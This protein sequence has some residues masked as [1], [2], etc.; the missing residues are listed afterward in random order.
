MEP[1]NAHVV[2]PDD[3]DPELEEDGPRLLRERNVARA[4]REDRNDPSTVLRTERP[5]DPNEAVFGQKLEGTARAGP[6]TPRP[7][8]SELSRCRP[9]DERSEPPLVQDPHNAEQMVDA[10]ALA[11]DD[12]GDADPPGPVPVQ[13][14]E[15]SDP[16][17][18]R[19]P[20]RAG[21]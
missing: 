7:K 8:R 16:K 6:G 18:S 9:R 3:L 20:A 12:L 4:P 19:V 15:M 17:R 14:R 21:G 11:E 10:L 2:R 1:G 13:L 5:G